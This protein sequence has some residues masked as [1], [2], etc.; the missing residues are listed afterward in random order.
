[1]LAVCFGCFALSACG[2]KTPPL[3]PSAGLTYRA[4]SDEND[5]ECYSVVN[6]GTC[7]DTVITIPSTYEG[8]P[9]IEIEAKAFEFNTKNGG[10]DTITKFNIPN[11]II[12][13]GNE[14]FNGRKGE[15]NFINP[16]IK[17]ITNGAFKGYLGSSFTIPNTVTSIGSEA[18]SF[19]NRTASEDAIT[20]FVIPSS[21]TSIGSRAFACRT[22]EIEFVN[23]TITTISHYAFQH[24]IGNGGTFTIPNTVTYLGREAFSMYDMQGDFSYAKDNISK[25]VIP[26]SVNEIDWY[27]FRD[28][29]AEIEF[30]N[31]TITTI[32]ER[33]FAD[34][35]GTSFTIP[36][37]VTTIGK[38]A[39][40]TC[41][42]ITSFTVPNTVTSIGIAAFGTMSAMTSFEFEDGIQIE[43]L[44]ADLFNDCTSLT[45]IEIPASVKRFYSD[46]SDYQFNTW[47]GTFRNVTATI[48]FEE[49]SQ[50]EHIG[51][52]YFLDF[53]GV[54]ILPSSLTTISEYAFYATNGGSV[55]VPATVTKI[56]SRGL[57][58][59]ENYLSRYDRTIIYFE[60]TRD[61][62]N[63]LVANSDSS[64]VI[65]STVYTSGEWQMID[66]VPTPNAI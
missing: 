41:N 35:R 49:G 28:R 10:E 36:R 29:S 58:S 64:A 44:P 24:Y 60:G 4:I 39:F 52:Y 2:D 30:D 23:P 20:K 51:K 53:K 65:E 33:A 26:N 50:L 43:E 63:T 17:E 37:T 21:V 27:P 11:S 40:S 8:K 32:P 19:A 56:E 3:Q 18:F 61:E 42:K 9:V 54:V 45:T 55:V 31:P 46:L 47:S 66:G 59:Y 34:Y 48:T 6:L 22:A 38:M 25:I 14:A 5:N 7:T 1:M 57:S 13:I 62:W 12:T 16:T 15:I